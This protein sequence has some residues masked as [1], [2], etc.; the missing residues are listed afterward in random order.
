MTDPPKQRMR[1]G[2]DPILPYPA[3]AVT[4]MQWLVRLAAKHSRILFCP[5]DPIYHFVFPTLTCRCTG[6]RSTLGGRRHLV[7]VSLRDFEDS[8]G[9]H[10]SGQQLAAGVLSVSETETAAACAEQTLASSISRVCSE[11]VKQRLSA[12][13]ACTAM[14]ADASCTSMWMGESMWPG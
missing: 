6:G 3:M 2:V 5:D 9:R 7:C 10:C 4:R 12:P 11:E 8:L 13:K 1:S 14:K